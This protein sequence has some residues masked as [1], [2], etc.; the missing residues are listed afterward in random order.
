MITLLIG[1]VSH[2]CV[3]HVVNKQLA[4]DKESK[5]GKGNQFF[6][7]GHLASRRSEP[8][9]VH[10][11]LTVGLGADGQ[12]IL[13]FE[14]FGCG[15]YGAADRNTNKADVFFKPLTVLLGDVWLDQSVKIFIGTNHVLANED[16]QRPVDLAARQDCACQE[17]GNEGKDVHAQGRGHNVAIGNGADDSLFVPAV[18]SLYIL[19][20]FGHIFRSAGHK[21]RIFSGFVQFVHHCGVDIN[22][23]GFIAGKIKPLADKTSA[24]ISGTIHDRF[25][26]FYF[27]FV[28]VALKSGRTVSNIRSATASGVPLASIRI[29]G[30]GSVSNTRKKASRKSVRLSSFS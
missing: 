11:K 1:H 23:C 12:R 27:S 3:P 9:R 25:H 8:G 13:F 10:R 22:K 24:D 2:Q 30:S 5:R 6:D 28:S 16:I 14:F 15:R 19:N 4:F 21:N 20:P 29:T 26:Y 7:G 18:Y 17:R